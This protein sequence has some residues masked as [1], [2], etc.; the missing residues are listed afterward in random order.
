MMSAL[1]SPSAFRTFEQWY[2]DP[3]VQ[4]LTSSESLGWKDIGIRTSRV[5][6]TEDYVTGPLCDEHSLVFQL[7][8]TTR[9]QTR[10]HD[11]TYDEYLTSGS[12]ALIPVRHETSGRWSHS[13][14]AAILQLSPRLITLLADSTLRGDPDHVQ[15]LP[16][17]NFHDPL[18]HYLII[19]LCNGLQNPSPLGTLF[20]ESAS[21]TIMLHLLRKYSNAAVTPQVPRAPLT[22]RQLGVINDYIESHFDQKIS[23]IDLASLLFMSLSHFERI[24]RASLGCPPY[25]Y[26]LERRIERAKLLL[27]NATLSLHEVARQCG[28]ANQSHLTKHF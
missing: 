8:G 13:V 20:A 15:L 17:M 3:V 19:E 4:P 14:S 10:L 1:N 28:F 24:F 22:P 7:E 16:R 27:S 23:L 11:K 12:M 2:A 18:L 26:I 5:V 9:L 21:H 6:A 25:R